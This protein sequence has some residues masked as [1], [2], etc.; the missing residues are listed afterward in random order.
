MEDVQHKS[1]ALSRTF[2]LLMKGSLSLFYAISR[3]S[4]AVQYRNIGSSIEQ[5]SFVCLDWFSV[6][7]R[8]LE[9]LLR[10][11]GLCICIHGAVTLKR[12][13]YMLSR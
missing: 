10:L 4:S 8:K 2:G 13:L 6:D 11:Q 1:Q 12:A 7:F 5:V 9:L 3:F